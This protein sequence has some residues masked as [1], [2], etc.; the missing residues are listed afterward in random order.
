MH[1]N[2]HRHMVFSGS[3]QNLPKSNVVFLLLMLI[4]KNVHKYRMWLTENL[5][6]T[7]VL[8]FLFMALQIEITIF[9]FCIIDIWPWSW[10]P[11]WKETWDLAV[12]VT[13]PCHTPTLPCSSVTKPS[14][15]LLNPS[16]G[17]PQAS[18]FD[19]DTVQG[20][21][22]MMYRAYLEAGANDGDW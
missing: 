19:H 13:V 12:I 15:F 9:S 22:A 16:K 18:L 2:A 10:L 11:L 21:Y 14:L 3:H 17:Y 4:F 1:V 6:S 8:Y 7:A 5:E 20:P